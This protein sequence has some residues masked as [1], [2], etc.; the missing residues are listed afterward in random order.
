[1][2]DQSRA[3]YRVLAIPRKARI[4]TSI[5]FPGPVVVEGTVVGDV[6]CIS[7]LIAV[8]GAVEGLIK[9]DDV[10][11]LGEVSGEIFA[12]RVALKDRSSVRAN[13]FHKHLSLEGGCRF[14]GK[15]NRH[16][17]PLQLA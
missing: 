15:S 9:A 2:L 7:L 4:E 1:M 14:E 16:A 6:R 17:N 12:T 3:S 8:C 13:I 11:V 5:D 10:T